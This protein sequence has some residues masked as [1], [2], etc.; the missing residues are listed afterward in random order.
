M[1]PPP[2]EPPNERREDRGRESREAMDPLF[3][4]G[5]MS[6]LAAA[7][8]SVGGI[9]VGGSHSLLGNKVDAQNESL[10]RVQVTLAKI[11]GKIDASE[12]LGARVEKGLDAL[13]TRVASLESAQATNAAQIAALREKK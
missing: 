3:R 1:T 2:H 8:I 4:K 5:P 7:M 10:Q 11:E 9:A 6:M 12:S 13:A